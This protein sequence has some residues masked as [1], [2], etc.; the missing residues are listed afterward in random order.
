MTALGTSPERID[1]RDV[2]S[3]SYWS[4]LCPNFSN[5]NTSD[6]QGKACPTCGNVQDDLPFVVRE[7]AVEIR[8]APVNE[9]DPRPVL[10][11][12]RVRKMAKAVS[13]IRTVTL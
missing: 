3:R 9:L 4:Q 6:A 12:S 11:Q 1:P 7:N 13:E 2:L 8:L 10:S 5:C